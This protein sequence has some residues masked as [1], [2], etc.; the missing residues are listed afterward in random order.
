MSLAGQAFSFA[1]SSR[2]HGLLVANTSIFVDK[3]P[4]SVLMDYRRA[5]VDI[6]L[7]PRCVNE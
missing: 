1:T 5:Y 7:E 2:T 4:K 3:L 6:S